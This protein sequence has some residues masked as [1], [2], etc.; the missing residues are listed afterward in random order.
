MR[1]YEELLGLVCVWTLTFPSSY[2]KANSMPSMPSTAAESALPGRAY[3]I[4]RSE[5]KHQYQS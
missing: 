5:S 2:F 4:E 3:A 1:Y